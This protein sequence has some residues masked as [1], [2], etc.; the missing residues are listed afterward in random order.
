MATFHLP[1]ARVG[2][3][4]RPECAT[5]SPAQAAGRARQTRVARGVVAHADAKAT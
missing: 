5:R 3:P 2:R 4:A 1:T